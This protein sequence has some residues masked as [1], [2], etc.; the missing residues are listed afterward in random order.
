M[1]D[2]ISLCPEE[3]L[4]TR[5]WLNGQ[6]APHCPH[7]LPCEPKSACNGSN[8]CNL[9]YT[10]ERCSLCALR[11]YRRAGECVECPDNPLI[12]IGAFLATAI[13]LMI[14]GYFLNKKSVNLAFVSIGVDYFQILALFATSRVT[15]PA[16]IKEI[17][18][19]MS[20]FNFNLEITAPECSFPE[21]GFKLKWM[22]IMAL[23]LAALTLFGLLHVSLVGYKFLILGRR[24]KL[25]R[26]APAMVGTILVMMYYLYLYLTRTTLDVFNEDFAALDHELIEHL[27]PHGVIT[28]GLDSP[29]VDIIDSK[30]L[31]A[32]GS[33]LANNIAILETLKL[34]GVSAG[35]YELL[36][37]PL[38]LIGFDGS[39]VRAALR[40][41]C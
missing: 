10:G 31:P 13:C 12:L 3:R 26:H 40:S 27:A 6:L 2:E 37:Q 29:S 14:G 25:N 28:I 9:G 41:I 35:R 20:A 15:W 39:P 30:D 22:L 8:T 19:L 18:T 11:Y 5:Q 21:L 4:Q 7:A 33:C 23:P 1:S 16:T 24:K 17:F 36:A 32:H 34:D 38:K